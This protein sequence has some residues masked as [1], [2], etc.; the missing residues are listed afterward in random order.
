M[1]NDTDNEKGKPL[2]NCDR[3]RSLRSQIVT[4][5]DEG[6]VAG[7]ARNDGHNDKNICSRL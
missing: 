3:F 6:E 2:T 1:G 7:Q 5:T 4:L